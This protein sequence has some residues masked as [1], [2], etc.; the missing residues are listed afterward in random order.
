[1]TRDEM[2]ADL[3]YARALAEEGRHAPLLGGAYLLFWGVLNAIAFAGQFAIFRGFLPFMDGMI[4]AVLWVSYGVIAGIGMALLRTRTSS[5]PGLSAIGT[6]AE[7][8]LWSGAAIA[9]LAVVIGSIS[10]M[11][12]TSDPSA[13]NAILGAAFALYGAA[14]FGTASLSEQTW[15]RGFGWLSVA[16]ALNC[17]MFAAYDWVYVIASIGSLLALA[18]PGIILLRREPS[19]IA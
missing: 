12:M 5:K 1:M 10:R 11:F 9:V 3:T 14:L 13:T 16:V 2:L 8:A 19:A 17:C 15:L 6:R 7:R 18:L 4:F